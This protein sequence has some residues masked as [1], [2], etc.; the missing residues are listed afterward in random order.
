MLYNQKVT[1]KAVPVS[2]MSCIHTEHSSQLVPCHVH[3]SLAYH[4]D[5]LAFIISRFAFAELLC[6][7]CTLPKPNLLKQS[8]SH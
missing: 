6:I 3:K 8:L 2:V 4:I 1:F 5:S 7:S